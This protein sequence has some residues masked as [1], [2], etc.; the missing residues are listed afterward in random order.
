MCFL[1]VLLIY[2]KALFVEKRNILVCVVEGKANTLHSYFQKKKKFLCRGRYKLLS[3]NVSKC[4][5]LYAYIDFINVLKI[6]FLLASFKI[7]SFKTIS[8]VIVDL[9]LPYLITFIE[10]IRKR[11]RP[12]Y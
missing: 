2:K 5:K 1:A 9:P 7:I 6:T 3:L 4:K 12:K 8:T 11:I 10:K